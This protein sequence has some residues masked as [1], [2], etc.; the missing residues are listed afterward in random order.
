MNTNSD[1]IKILIKSSTFY[2]SRNFVPLLIDI[3][4]IEVKDEELKDAAYV[5][6]DEI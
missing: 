2:Y 3:V 1:N 5:M 6:L 4:D